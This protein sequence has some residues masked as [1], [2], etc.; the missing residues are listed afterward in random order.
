MREGDNHSPPPQ[1]DRTAEGGV[2]RQHV[3]RALGRLSPQERSV[4][5]LRHYQDLPLKEIAAALN[6]AEGTVKVH[7]FRAVRRLQKELHFLR[8]DVGLEGPR[9]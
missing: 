6:L 1:P 2:I 7:L 8:T 5:V 9:P 4:F 3:E